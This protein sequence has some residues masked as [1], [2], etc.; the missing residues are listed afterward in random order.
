[1]IAILYDVFIVEPTVISGNKRATRGRRE[2]VSR[3]LDLLEKNGER[4]EETKQ[5]VAQIY[6][7]E[8]PERPMVEFDVTQT[9]DWRYSGILWQWEYVESPWVNSELDRMLD[10]N[11]QR[12]RYQLE[13][14]PETD[15]VPALEGGGA[16]IA[17]MF[18]A[19]RTSLPG[20]SGS[21]FKKKVIENLEH[22]IALL[23]EV[24]PEKIEHCAD[25][26]EKLRFLAEMT[27]GKVL[28]TYP[29]M[30]GALNT[31]SDLMGIDEMLIATS[32]SKDALRKLVLRISWA[33]ARTIKAFQRAVGEDL[34]IPRRRFYQPPW[35]KGL[36]VDDFT[37]VIRP[38]DYYE[39]CA[40]GWDVLN[41]EV[42]A[43]YLHTCGPVIQCADLFTRLPGLA[44]F[45]TVFVYPNSKKTNELEEM[46]Y[47]LNGKVVMSSLGLPVATDVWCSTVSDPENLTASWLEE[48]SKG[49]GFNMH[50]WGT[51]DE[52]RQLLRRLGL[53]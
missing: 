35:V 37:A 11:I 12:I 2:S 25:A 49:G 47:R 42:G 6:R 16:P 30:G 29:S 10:H 8:T 50:N 36:Q 45:E 5:L 51:P 33:I 4:I 26:L 7:F 43:S 24:E 28:L 17:E 19:E 34:L 3:F 40:D 27:D 18:G 22:D 21:I 52:G 48:M 14:L 53:L 23:P 1:M 38:D 46:K 20:R 13:N 44:A 32:I 15:Y 31:A 39:I 41:K 9:P